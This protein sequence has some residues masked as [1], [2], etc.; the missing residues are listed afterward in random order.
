[1]SKKIALLFPG[2]GSQYP[3]MGKEL[4]EKYIEVRN[5]FQQADEILGFELSK[6]VFAGPDETL[7][8]TEYTQPAIFVTSLAI[9]EAVKKHIPIAEENLFACG[10]SLGEYTA[11]AV[12]GAFSLKDGLEL[13]RARGEFIARASAKNPG[14][15]VAV[16]GLKKDKVIEVC[17]KVKSETGQVCEPVNFNA[18]NQTVVAG[19]EKSILLLEERAKEYGA[20]RVV[21]LNVSGPF[22]SSLMTEAAEMMAEKLKN[23]QFQ[24]LR[25]PVVSN[26]DA[27]ITRDSSELKEKLIQQINHPVLW[28]ETIN[29]LKNSGVDIFL[30]VGPKNV[31]SNLVTQIDR[32]S[33]VYNI[34]DEKTLEQAKTY[35]ANSLKIC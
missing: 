10:H 5:I 28:V 29:I 8:R 20:K 22:H 32:N 4:A 1:M 25:F 15:L 33:V 35:L 12:A 7:R 18:P 9:W 16:L 24:Q 19:T 30:E 23:F 31:L 34:E 14:G 21:R 11:L 26:W 3:G 17:D 13:V 6:I 2:Q 27:K